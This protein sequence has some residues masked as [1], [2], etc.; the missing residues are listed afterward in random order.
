MPQLIQLAT[1]ASLI[2]YIDDLPMRKFM[3]ALFSTYELHCFFS[4]KLMLISILAGF[5][6]A[7]TSILELLRVDIIKECREHT[8]KINPIES[9][10]NRLKILRQKFPQ[11]FEIEN[12]NT[13]LLKNY[14]VS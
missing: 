4:N 2:V 9:D 13:N 1:I 8:L 10:D 6:R 11:F 3:C 5:F 7:K 14:C 12:R